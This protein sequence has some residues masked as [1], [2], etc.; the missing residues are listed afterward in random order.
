MAFSLD[1]T[2]T[3]NA[4]RGRIVSDYYYMTT[5][6]GQPPDTVLD[7]LELVLQATILTLRAMPASEDSANGWNCSVASDYCHRNEPFSS[8]TSI[9]SSESVAFP[10]SS[11]EVSQDSQ[12]GDESSMALTP[13]QSQ[14]TSGGQSAKVSDVV[15]KRRTTGHSTFY[16]RAF[17]IHSS[18]QDVHCQLTTKLPAGTTHPPYL[19][20]LVVSFGSPGILSRLL[21]ALPVLRHRTHFMLPND[22]MSGNDLL[23]AIDVLENRGVVTTIVLRMYL[24]YL[25]KAFEERVTAVMGVR[26]ASRR[27]RAS[28]VLDTMSEE[29]EKASPTRSPHSWQIRRTTIKNNLAAGKFWCRV[30]SR[31]SIGAVALCSTD[32]SNTNNEVTHLLLTGG[33]NLT[34]TDVIN[35]QALAVQNISYDSN[36]L[37]EKLSALRAAEGPTCG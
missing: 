25:C 34:D 11:S 24:A 6:Q 29:Y 4:L 27:S 7:Q 35:E 28:E 8:V 9:Y 30:L 1:N 2:P 37:I 36:D 18:A 3:L 31:F 19:T 10:W 17:R 32:I 14:Q 23:K 12:Q 16:D 26:S 21:R 22:N 15:K 5:N 13:S 20:F 33:D